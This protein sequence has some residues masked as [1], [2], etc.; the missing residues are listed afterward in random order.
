M[1]AFAPAHWPPA[2]WANSLA[3]A[4]FAKPGRAV[5]PVRAVSSTFKLADWLAE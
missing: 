2:L 1:H 4:N 5:Y 3:P